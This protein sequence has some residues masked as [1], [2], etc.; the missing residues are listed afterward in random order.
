MR[1]L[2]PWATRSQRRDAHRARYAAYITS[3]EWYQRRE[4]WALEE[5]RRST[6]LIRCVGCRKRW[7]LHRDD[8]H[9]L[10]YERLG[11]E[12]H[13]DLW[14]MCR[15]CHNRLHD[16]IESTKSWRKLS[17]R[18]ANQRG[19]EVVQ[20]IRDVAAPHRSAAESMRDYL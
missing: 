13:E 6:E 16:L 20:Q 15:T 3:P 14:P 8:L 10:S 9:H 7:N 5:V 12:A 4:S 19:L 1:E 2:S 11:N 18:L 17:R